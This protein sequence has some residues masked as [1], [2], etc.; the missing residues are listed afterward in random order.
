MI[1]RPVPVVYTLYRI[2]VSSHGS[3]IVVWRHQ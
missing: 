2:I 3:N 1:E